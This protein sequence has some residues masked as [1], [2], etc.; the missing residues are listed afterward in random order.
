MIPFLN[1]MMM[2]NAGSE[3]PH[4]PQNRFALI[5]QTGNFLQRDIDQLPFEPDLIWAKPLS[6][7][8][9]EWR[10][11]EVGLDRVMNSSS[12]SLPTA[13]NGYNAIYSY[14]AFCFKK[15]PRFLDIIPYTGNGTSQIIRHNLG[16]NV[17]FVVIKCL[18]ATANWFA[19]GR[20][21][22]HSYKFLNTSG[23]GSPV[24]MNGVTFI[25]QNQ[26][27]IGDLAAINKNGQ[28]YVA[29]IF[30]DDTAS[31]GIIR[32]G[33]QGTA[34]SGAVTL[35]LGWRPQWALGKAW[36]HATATTS[37]NWRIVDHVS[38]DGVPGNSMD[39]GVMTDSTQ[40]EFTGSG[41]SKATN[42]I[43]F[44]S[45]SPFNT[46]GWQYLYLF[47]REPY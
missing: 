29:Y 39:R 41:V 32:L 19:V 4:L 24:V 31:D 36:A 46:T 45:S 34:P 11:T 12:T 37:Q 44:T 1:P 28:Q 17:A 23:L 20:D 10:D 7:G 27:T 15:A 40:A 16:V 3:T 26:I 18:S 25:N 33:Y 47:I 42:G 8:Q 2:G 22:Y 13:F 35:N 6:L 38:G 43:S 14:V 9:W 21:N 30:A 5:H